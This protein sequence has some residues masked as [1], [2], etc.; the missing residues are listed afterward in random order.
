VH[1]DV[2]A[3]RQAGVLKNVQKKVFKLRGKRPKTVS[4][5]V[6]GH[7]VAPLL[8]RAH[9]SPSHLLLPHRYKKLIT[10]SGPQ[11]TVVHTNLVLHK[12]FPALEQVTGRDVKARIA[13]VRSIRMSVRVAMDLLFR[14]SPGLIA[15]V[16]TLQ[17]EDPTVW[18]AEKPLLCVHCRTR[19]ADGK[20]SR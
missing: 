11:L 13:A 14:P 17:Q 3:W 7:V 5:C 1:W 10:G 12:L 4:L 16:H 8:L 20:R 9:S 2:K 15:R 18:T 19:V 6:C